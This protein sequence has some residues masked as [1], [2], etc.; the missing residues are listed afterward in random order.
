MEMEEGKDPETRGRVGTEQS[1]EGPRKRGRQTKH[2]N[3]RASLTVCARWFGNH[4]NNNRDARECG[5]K[6]D[7]VSVYCRSSDV[8][9]QP[10]LNVGLNLK[11][12]NNL[13]VQFNSIQFICIAQFHKLQISL[14]VLYNLYT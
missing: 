9:A 4:S 2:R 8:S 14:G 7:P 10:V 1:I 3:K 5:R 13:Q 6:V 12:L 11:K